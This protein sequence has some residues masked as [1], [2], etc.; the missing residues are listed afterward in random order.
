MQD[1]GVEHRGVRITERDIVPYALATSQAGE[2][3]VRTFDISK[4]RNEAMSLASRD[5]L[6]PYKADFQTFY[7]DLAR[8]LN[9]LSD[10]ENAVPTK[11]LFG[12]AAKAAYMTDFFG[13]KDGTAA[14]YIRNFTLDRMID[15]RPTGEK[16]SMSQIAYDRNKAR[17]M[18]S[19]LFAQR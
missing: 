19:Q 11:E 8:Y 9:N 10:R 2:L 6:G 14:K 12:D 1:G 15:M 4:A 17:F 7:G 13:G 3:F 16:V 18:F 5:R